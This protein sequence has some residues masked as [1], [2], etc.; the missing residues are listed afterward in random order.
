MAQILAI[1]S[2]NQ[3]VPVSTMAK[4]TIPAKKFIQNVNSVPVSMAN[5]RVK[6]ARVTPHVRL[7]THLASRSL[8]EKTSDFYN[9]DSLQW[10][11]RN[12]LNCQ[13]EWNYVEIINVYD[14]LSYILDH[15]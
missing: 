8:T 11:K 4:F 3:N 1:V 5:G 13:F 14:P 7:V 15:R 6:Q 10:S 12:F 9:P 2:K